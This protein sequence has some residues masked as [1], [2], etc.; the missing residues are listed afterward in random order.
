MKK[1]K[2]T[3]ETLIGAKTKTK[4]KERLL[5]FVA[6][7]KPAVKDLKKTFIAGAK[8]GGGGAGGAHLPPPAMTYGSLIQLVFCKKKLFGLLV[9]R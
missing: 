9:L 7:Y 3:L 5:P 2:K 6:T 4:N 8:L 1:K